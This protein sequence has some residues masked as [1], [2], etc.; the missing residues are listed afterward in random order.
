[1]KKKG[2]EGGKGTEGRKEGIERGRRERDEVSILLHHAKMTRWREGSHES[3]FQC[4]YG[5]N[6]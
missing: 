6:L 2:E 1:M 3:N 4:Q 5:N